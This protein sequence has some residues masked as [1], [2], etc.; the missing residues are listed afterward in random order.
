MYAS[1]ATRSSQTSGWSGVSSLLS[2]MRPS[3]YST[4][5]SP[6]RA[7]DVRVLFSAQHFRRR[8]RQSRVF[9]KEWRLFVVA[10]EASPQHRA[11]EPCA[12]GCHATSDGFR[13]S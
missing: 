11:E 5:G 10:V 4:S 12:G 1:L 3:D 13:I 2:T 6:D 7:H 8:D 9:V